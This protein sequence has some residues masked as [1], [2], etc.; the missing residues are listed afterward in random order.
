MAK[1]WGSKNASESLISTGIY[2]VTHN[3]GH[4]RYVP[5]VQVNQ[6][7]IYATVTDIYANYFTVQIRN[8]SGNALANGRFSYHIIGDNYR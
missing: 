3:F 4:T 6:S 5:F 7:G 2:R 1:I 8:I